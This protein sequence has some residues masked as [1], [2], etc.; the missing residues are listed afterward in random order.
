MYI[1]I[2]IYMFSY[3]GPEVFCQKPLGEDCGGVGS[4][5]SDTYHLWALVG[6]TSIFTHTGNMTWLASAWPHLTLG[7]DHSLSKIGDQGL[8]VVDQRADWQRGGQGGANSVANVLLTHITSEAA[9]MAK[10]LNDPA[11]QAKYANASSALSAALN[12]P[13][14]WDDDKGAFKDNPD[15]TLYPQDG[16]SVALW[17]GVVNASNAGR[18][19]DY[20]SSNWVEL[21]SASPEWSG[22]IGNSMCVCV[23]L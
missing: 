2:Y 12:S 15:S 17:F 4:W 1:Y 11:S 13:L 16:N 5:I 9:R 23:C 14:M 3:V 7:I 8:M 22:N 19:S 18:V 10:A 6:A 21:G 20:L